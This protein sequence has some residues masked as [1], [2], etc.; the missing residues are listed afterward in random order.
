MDFGGTADPFVEMYKADGA[1][2]PI[3]KKPRN[4]FFQ[5]LP[6][7]TGTYLFTPTFN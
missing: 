6:L 5:Q 3:G 2:N 4:F 1:G 7:F